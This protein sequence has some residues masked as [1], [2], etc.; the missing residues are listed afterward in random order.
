MVFRLVLS[1]SV[2]LA[3]SLQSALAHEGHD[4]GPVS[5]KS[6][7]EIALKTAR[8]YTQSPSPFMGERLAPGWAQL[9]SA[10]ARIHE[11]GRGFYWVVLHNPQERRDLYIKIL[12][13]GEIAAATFDEKFLSDS[14]SSNNSGG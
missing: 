13:D 10:D 3:L 2:W 1:I 5:I 7:L 12:L 14:A 11:N 9:G 8:E 6:A 4:H